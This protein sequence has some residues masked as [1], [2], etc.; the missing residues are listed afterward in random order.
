MA[1]LHARA[2]NGTITKKGHPIR[3]S[4]ISGALKENVDRPRRTN[5]GL[6]HLLMGNADLGLRLCVILNGD[7]V[8]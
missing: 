7:D 3:G 6:F 4:L 2:F 5:D 8:S 1:S